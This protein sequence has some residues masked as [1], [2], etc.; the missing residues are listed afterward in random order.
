MLP[1]QQ[2]ETKDDF[3]MVWPLLVHAMGAADGAHKVRWRESYLKHPAYQLWVLKDGGRARG[4]IGVRLADPAE[5][6]HIA[7]APDDRSRGYGTLLFK[8][9]R[10]LKSGLARWYAETDDEAVGF[11]RRLGFTVE[12]L[13]PQY[14]GVNRYRCE[15]MD[16]S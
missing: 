5:I 1:L 6:T 13:P 11:Y 12:M 4:V 14:P 2:V 3:E 15:W 16:L 10:E 7:V 8:G 9:V